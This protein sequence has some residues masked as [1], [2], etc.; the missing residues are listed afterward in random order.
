LQSRD[1]N[2]LLEIAVPVA[3]LGPQ[4]LRKGFYVDVGRKSKKRN[5]D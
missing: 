5:E 4:E 3:K 1:K 2:C